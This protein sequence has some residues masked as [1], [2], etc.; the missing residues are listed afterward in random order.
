MM[1][2]ILAF[3]SNP[4]I[5]FLLLVLGLAGVLIETFHFGFIIPGVT[6]VAALGLALWAISAGPVDVNWIGVGLVALAAVLIAMETQLDARGVIGVAGIASLIAGGLM[7]YRATGADTPAVS[8]WL[9]GI[10]SGTIAAVMA[11]VVYMCISSRRA[12]K[13]RSD[14]E[15]LVGQEAVVSSPIDP[16]GI[17]VT[18]EGT[19]TAIS[20]DGEAISE[21]EP[22][23][24]VA[25]DGLVLTVQ[26]VQP[27]SK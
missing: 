2:D 16:T 23:R 15:R 26:M 27:A 7:L 9:I 5:V 19:W 21:G 3:I 8:L 6:G 13:G 25:M 18:P 11:V 17:I 4:N 22:V 20:H 14:A 24:I 12:H 1:T 10:T